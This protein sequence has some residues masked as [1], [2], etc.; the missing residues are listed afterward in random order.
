[1]SKYTDFYPSKVGSSFPYTG[2][3]FITGSLAVTGSG[4]FEYSV[5]S[6]G[7]SSGGPLATPRGILGAAGTQAA[8]LAFGGST[9]ASTAAT[10]EYN[11]VA[12]TWS[13]GNST[14]NSLRTGVAGAGTQQAA[15]AFGGTDGS[16][17]E[18]RRATE[19]YSSGV[20]SSK[21]DLI[22]GRAYLAGAGTQTAAL[23]FGGSPAITSTEQQ[24]DVI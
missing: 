8:A 6:Y 1:M 19:E 24:E 4:N 2:S 20:W 14:L 18:S 21:S 9:P 13:P 15:L 7:W 5:V 17:F 11:G 3:A 12:Q 22:P 10:E 16:T 23:A